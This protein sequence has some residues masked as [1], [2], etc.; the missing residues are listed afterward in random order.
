MMK[1]IVAEEILSKSDISSLLN[2]ND[3]KDAVKKTIKDDRNLEK[4][5]EAKVRKMIADAVNN[6]FKGLWEKNNFWRGIIT[7][8]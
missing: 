8:S 4:E 3:F 2:S 5:C 6:L 1:R 7:N